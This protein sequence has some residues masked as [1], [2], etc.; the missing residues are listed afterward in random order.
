MSAHFVN[1]TFGYK[2]VDLEEDRVLKKIGEDCLDQLRELW[3]KQPYMKYGFVLHLGPKAYLNMILS[4]DTI[5]PE[6]R[7]VLYQDWEESTLIEKERFKIWSNRYIEL[8]SLHE[9]IEAMKTDAIRH[10]DEFLKL[11]DT[12]VRVLSPEK[13]LS[14]ELFDSLNPETLVVNKYKGQDTRDAGDTTAKPTRSRKSSRGRKK[15]SASN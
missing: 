7:M 14:F 9:S 13:R 11:R 15:V 12:A 3:R 4:D 5:S 10:G 1:H 6:E 8:E 2:V